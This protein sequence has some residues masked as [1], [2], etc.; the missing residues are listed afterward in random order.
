MEAFTRLDAVAVP[1]A[2][3]N[4]DTDQIVPALYLQKPRSANFGDFLFRD[5]RRD[6]EGALRPDFPLNDP[7][8]AG[9]RILVAGR[10]FGCGSSREHA[11]WALSDGGF[12]AVIAPSFGDIFF[13]NAQKNGLLPVR[14]AEAL[15]DGLL[16][17]L[18]A[19]PGTKLCIDLAAQSVSAPDGSCARF[20]IDPF[21]RHCLLEG[22]DEL[23]YT[24]TQSARIEAFERARA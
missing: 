19:S 2:R 15:V 9:A 24:L 3:G 10:N 21:A 11:V 7:A 17:T 12:R 4:I 1:L 18:Q 23:D 6:A 16:A 8:Y 13:S 20:E 14:L 5:V 22:L